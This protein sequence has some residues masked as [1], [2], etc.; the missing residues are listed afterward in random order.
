M[1]SDS[2][3]EEISR[4]EGKFRNITNASLLETRKKPDNFQSILENTY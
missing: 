2:R 1:S 3:E 4:L